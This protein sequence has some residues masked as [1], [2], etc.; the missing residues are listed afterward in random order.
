M[1]F[2]SY[3][4]G[5]DGDFR[6]F[7]NRE[8][9]VIEARILSVSPDLKEMKISRRDGREFMLSPLEMDLDCQQYIKGWVAANPMSIDFRLDVSKAL[10]E[11]TTLRERDDYYE[12]RAEQCGYEVT[13]KNLT[14]ETIP[15]T[16]VDYVFCLEDG[17]RIYTSDG[18]SELRWTEYTSP[19]IKL[20]R[21]SVEI[22]ELPYN[23]EFRFESDPHEVEKV[24]VDNTVYAEDK[25]L[26]MRMR[27]RTKSG[28]LI[29]EYGSLGGSLADQSWEEVTGDEP[30]DSEV[31][32][33][34]KIEP[35]SQDILLEEWPEKF[36]FGEFVKSRTIPDPVGKTVKVSGSA[37]IGSS[38]SEGVIVAHGGLQKGWAIFLKD[39][40]IHFMVKVY[41]DRTTLRKSVSI[42][43]AELG[44]SEFPFRALW[45]GEV[46]AL[47]VGEGAPVSDVSPG[48][49]LT[50]PVEGISIGFDSE[51][52]RVA[53]VESS[54][55][56]T[57]DVKN[58]TIEFVD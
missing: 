44:T 20:V 55:W 50:K 29:G 22:Q 12:Y 3:V 6:D 24:Q 34:S 49:L 14:R 54:S 11:R 9:N 38:T 39:E 7:R 52:T 41:R 17:A 57:G 40:K 5:Q 30:E 19:E 36:Q 16:V 32:S 26:G 53:P 27:I 45:S 42:P 8:G 35:R 33:E 43:V 10:K 13:I 56:L 31:R 4:G 37:R 1:T 48:L 18:G 51:S 15:E 47:E 25:I 46:I 2:S 23:H 21:G 58:V 28:V